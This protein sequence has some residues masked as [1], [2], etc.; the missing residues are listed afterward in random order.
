MILSTRNPPR[1]SPPASFSLGHLR[2]SSLFGSGDSR[3]RFLK[4]SS[5]GAGLPSWYL[6]LLLAVLWALVLPLAAAF[7]LLDLFLPLVSFLLL[8][9]LEPRLSSDEEERDPEVVLR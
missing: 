4:L 2:W 3:R 1:T 5:D 6:L 9:V 7:R 8:L